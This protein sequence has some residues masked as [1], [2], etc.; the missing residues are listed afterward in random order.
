M[1]VG[2]YGGR[3]LDEADLFRARGHRPGQRG[4]AQQEILGGGEAGVAAGLHQGCQEG[5][6]G[7]LRVG[8]GMLRQP[9]GQHDQARR[10]IRRGQNSA[11]PAGRRSR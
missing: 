9:A 5:V 8:V 3:A 7:E 11:V 1:G 2:G 10:Q 4:E 6:G